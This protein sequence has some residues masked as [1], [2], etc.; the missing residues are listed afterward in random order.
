[1]TQPLDRTCQIEPVGEVDAANG[2]FWVNN[3]FLLLRAAENLSAYEKNRLFLNVDGSKFV[4]SSFAAVADIDSDSRSVVAGDFDRDGMP[5]LLVGSVGGG[6]LRLFRNQLSGEHN[7]VQVKLVGE[8]SNRAA[9]GA[10]VTIEIGERT[11]FRDRFCANGFMGQGPA[12]LPIGIGDASVIDRLKIRWPS[13]EEQEF[14][15]VPVNT[16]VVIHEGQPELTM[17]P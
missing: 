11:L 5:D 14:A 10:R 6:P 7:W 16:S 15:N 4:D 2:E 9:I 8:R 13:G 1:M 12:E 3:P 17:S